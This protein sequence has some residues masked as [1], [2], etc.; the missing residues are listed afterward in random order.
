M[1]RLAAAAAAMTTFITVAVHANLRPAIPTTWDLQALRT[2]DM[3][4]ADRSVTRTYMSPEEYYGLPVRPVYKSYPIY[5]PGHEPAGYIDWLQ[6]QEPEVI[7]DP[8]LL[9]TTDDWVRAGAL[10]F[11]APTAAAPLADNPRFRDPEFY[12]ATEM[13][14]TPDGV[15][16]FQRY[17]VR[18]KGLV[19]VGFQ[20]CTQCHRR[21][22]DGRILDGVQGNLPAG[23]ADAFQIRHSPARREQLRRTF[24]AFFAMPWLH[25]DPLD[26]I[27]QMDIDQIAA[28]RE[29]MPAGVI[30]RQGTNPKWPAAVSDLIGVKERRF[31]DHTATTRHRDIGDLMRYVAMTQGMDVRTRYNG[32]EP[33]SELPALLESGRTRYSDEQ[34]Y[35]LSLYLYSLR[36]P[37]NPNRRDALTA[38]GQQVFEDEGCPSCHRPPLYT[39]NMLVPANGFVVPREDRL[40]FDILRQPIGLDTNLTL[41]GRRGTGYYTVPS[42]KGVWYRG[43][44]GHSGSVPTLEDW[45]NPARLAKTPGH[46]FG[47]DLPAADK[48]ALIAFLKTIE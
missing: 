19:E 44:F 33:S 30:T 48:A 43:P 31:L 7:F 46:G 29:R 15:Y 20:S 39:N 36:P 1:L 26:D 9:H 22:I 32:W 47:L 6:Q 17:V 12:R 37:E 2:F 23:R 8:A 13:P 14:L 35:A 25:P 45:F 24:R 10:V 34:L 18:K 40:L 41:K 42:L 11:E 5:E 16:P 27:E 4:L 28:M 3:P 21:V 38:R